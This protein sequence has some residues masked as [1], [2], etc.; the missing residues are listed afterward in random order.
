MRVPNDL[1]VWKVLIEWAHRSWSLKNLVIDG[2]FDSFEDGQSTFLVVLLERRKQ[3]ELRE[4][5]D[6]WE[7]TI[8][9]SKKVLM[10]KFGG[11]GDVMEVFG[12]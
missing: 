11:G 2:R 4:E 6:V 7:R 8:Y 1:S 10:I 5:L 9:I 12:G 3:S